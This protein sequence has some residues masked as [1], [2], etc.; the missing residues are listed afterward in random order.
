[1]DNGMDILKGVAIG[2]VIGLVVAVVVHL[3][4]KDKAWFMGCGDEELAAAASAT[5]ALAGCT[6]KAAACST[7][8]SAADDALAKCKSDLA[9]VM[10][11]ARGQ[12]YCGRTF[13]YTAY[14]DGNT[15]TMPATAN[16][17]PAACATACNGMDTCKAW[18]YTD[19][20]VCEGIGVGSGTDGGAVEP[21]FSMSA[22]AEGYPAFSCGW[23]T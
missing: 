23:S 7:E 18:R 12:V 17:S 6:A 22:I 1:M 5:E 3:V 16:A 15:V 8:L 14:V 13:M 21:P 19:A 20:D 10:T 2:L 11:P 4:T 9:A